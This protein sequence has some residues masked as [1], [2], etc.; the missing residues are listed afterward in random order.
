[1]GRMADPFAAI[2]RREVEGATLYSGPEE[3]PE[4]Q[5][6]ASVFAE[7]PQF[8]ATAHLEHREHQP[9]PEG[10]RMR[11]LA[12]LPRHWTDAMRA[13]AQSAVPSCAQPERWRQIVRDAA[14]FL[15]GWHDL[16][17]EM[18]WTVGHVFGLD[19]NESNGAVGLALSI[20]GGKVR[21]LFIDERGRHAAQLARGRTNEIV[22]R[23]ID[24]GAPPL[25]ALADMEQR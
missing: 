13:F 21:R 14:A 4:H 17:D 16:A 15:L 5:N 12:H 9:E 11:D 23:S 1:M 20:K 19:P 24:A 2:R 25:W 7:K 10:L 3:H 8:S 18:G 22:F 6:A